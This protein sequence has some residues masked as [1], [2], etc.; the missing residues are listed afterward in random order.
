MVARQIFSSLVISALVLACRPDAPTTPTRAV[1]T[2]LSASRSAE[3]GTIL[4]DDD[5]LDCPQA[6]FAN[7]Q[8]AVAAA[9]PGDRILVCRGTY[10][11]GVTVT[12]SDLRILALGV[13][14]H[15]VVNAHHHEFGIRVLNA[16]GVTIEGFRVVE[17]HEADIAL[18]NARW[19][20]VRGT[21]TSAAGHDG[22]QLVA[23]E[24]NLIEHNHVVDNLAANACG[25]N[26][27]G[28]SQRNVVR[29]NTLVNNE[30]G[31][32]ISGATTL[33][34][35]ISDNVA[36]GNRG[37]G[38]RNI[39]GASGTIIERNHARANGLTPGAL[40]GTTAAGIRVAGG[41]RITVR[42]NAAVENR[43]ADLLKDA[44]ALAAFERNRCETSSP[45]GLC[46]GG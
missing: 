19:N 39:N 14:G 10:H 30:W 2:D 7:I 42:G 36:G 22:I 34:N 18:H 33:D 23:A 26:V 5:G 41:S 17:A 46:Q 29:H 25:V 40:T 6:A 24:D 16:S 37:N 3:H 21:I 43:L 35:H 4:V 15:V 13:P 32:Q 45:E 28:G 8:G 9:A 38:I 20:T 44:A 11:E 27:T 12:T 1:G 31:I